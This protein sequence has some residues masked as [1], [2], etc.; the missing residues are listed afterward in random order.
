MSSPL[1]GKG[2]KR[3]ELLQFKL[4]LSHPHPHPQNLGNCDFFPYY[5]HARH[6]L[7]SAC[8]RAHSFPAEKGGVALPQR[9]VLFSPSSWK[10]IALPMLSEFFRGLSWCEGFFMLGLVLFSSGIPCI[11]TENTHFLYCGG[12]FLCHCGEPRGEKKKNGKDSQD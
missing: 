9:L 6:A 1:T 3:L 11:P 7:N 4:H 8:E 10:S 2:V 5:F 12:W